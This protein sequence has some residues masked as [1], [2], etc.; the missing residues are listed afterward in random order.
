MSHPRTETI[1]RYRR[2]T[3][4]VAVEYAGTFGHARAVATTLGAGGMF[5]ASEAPLPTGTRFTV[6]FSLPGTHSV[7]EIPAHVVWSNTSADANGS[8]VGMGIAF[9]DRRA[10]ASLAIALETLR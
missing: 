7:H 5:I 10:C 9:D 2:R 3:V 8:G 4:R 1:R 6:R